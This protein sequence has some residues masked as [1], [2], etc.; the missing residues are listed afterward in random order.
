MFWLAGELKLKLK[1]VELVNVMS[2]QQ[3]EIYSFSDS[4]RAEEASS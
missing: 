4:L 1:G 3:D 2:M